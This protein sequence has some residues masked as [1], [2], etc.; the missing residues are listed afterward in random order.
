MRK[1][2]IAIGLAALALAVGVGVL[3]SA[4]KP[5]NLQLSSQ[6]WKEDLQ[7][8]ARELPQRHANAFHFTQR[9]E[10]EKAVADLDAQLNH[11]DADA[12]W[13][14][15]QRI[16]SLVGDGH[17]Y[18]RTPRDSAGFP[19]NIER[20]GE[21]Y[22]IVSV[23]PGLENALGA[24]VVKVGD[25]PVARAA[26][27]CKELFSRDENPSL[28]EGFIDDALTTGATLH[29]LGIIADRNTGRYALIDDSGREFSTDVHPLPPGNKPTLIWAFKDPP[30]Y[31]Q[32]PEQKFACKYL[33]D[34]RALYCNVR[35]IRDLSGPVDEMLKLIRQQNPDKLV[36][37]LRQNGGGD[38]TVGEKHLI[39]PIRG[40]PS[41]NQKGHLFVL[42]GANTFSAAMNNAA[43]FRSQTNA[44][45]VGQEIGEKPNSYQ[46]PRNMTLPNSHLMVRYS[47]RFYHFTDSAD[48]AIRPDQ[49]VVPTWAEYKAGA[50][51]V[52]EWVLKYT[53]K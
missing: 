41:I 49:E 47:T 37:D 29:G 35:A 51:P 32:N 43:Q 50:D 20:F 48:N 3:W 13:V 18:L 46:E 21:E 34:S 33:P 30:L 28:A 1:T 6:Q 45:L 17:T 38:Y 7:F 5:E 8:L 25:T 16:T 36:I 12:A 27:L 44:I 53:S 9:A 52:L 23:V 24:R 19:I 2:V 14:G 31:R 22:R 40:L 11:S 10:F 4:D 42:I 39:H 26:D 15:M